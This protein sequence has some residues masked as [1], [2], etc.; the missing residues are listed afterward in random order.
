MRCWVD[1]NSQ[2]DPAETKGKIR[3]LS[4]QGIVMLIFYLYQ[5]WVACM[6]LISQIKARWPSSG[7][8]SCDAIIMPYD[9]WIMWIAS[10]ARKY[11]LYGCLLLS[12]FLCVNEVSVCLK[13]WVSLMAYLSQQ[14]Y[15]P[16]LHSCIPHVFMLFSNAVLLKGALVL[17]EVVVA[18]SFSAPRPC[19][20]P[21]LHLEYCSSTLA[22]LGPEMSLVG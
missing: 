13:L 8:L 18:D 11:I 22:I 10:A 5:Y 1:E 21:L 6:I 7:H 14:M 12:S 3:W 20:F 15:S 2:T 9:F 16:L 19:C 4:F 17:V